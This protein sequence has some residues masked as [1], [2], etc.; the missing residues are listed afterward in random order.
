MS[1]TSSAPTTRTLLP[2]YT[3]EAHVDSVYKNLRNI[4]KVAQQLP[5]MR[6][7]LIST[8]SIEQRNYLRAYIAEVG[9]YANLY[10]TFQ[11][12][13][14]THVGD[15]STRQQAVVAENMED[16][17]VAQRALAKVVEEF[18]MALEGHGLEME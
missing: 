13:Y 1:A 11:E 3:A 6:A 8:P 15:L 10:E 7:W 2:I 5:L 9:M 17:R 4:E 14:E 12:I 18:E 16:I